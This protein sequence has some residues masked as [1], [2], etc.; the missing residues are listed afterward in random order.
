M[1]S[2]WGR[3]S[4]FSTISRV[5]TLAS[6]LVFV[7][8]GPNLQDYVANGNRY[9]DQKQY[10]KAIVE[11]QNALVLNPQLGEVRAKLADAYRETNDTGRAV[12]EYIRAADLLP[13][14]IP[15]QLVAIRAFLTSARFEDA[16][17]RAEQV[18]RRDPKNAVAE[19]LLG[20][21]LVGLKDMDGAERETEDAIQ[22]D[23]ANAGVQL[24]LAALK[25]TQ[26]NAAAAE[27]AFEKAA[28]LDPSV[29]T[30]LSL[31]NFY[32][33]IDRQSDAENTFK[34]AV[35]AS[36]ADATANRS[37]A[38]FY[39]ATGR[40]RLA[41]PYLQALAKSS[42]DT[43]TRV[44]LA[45]YYV[46]LSEPARAIDILRK[47]GADATAQWRLASLQYAAG[48]KADGHRI[49]DDVL[50]RE[51][52]NERALLVKAN[53]LLKENKLDEA[54]ARAK[55]A[56]AADPRLVS[57]HFALGLIYRAKKQLDESIAA[58]SE[59]LR[60]NPRA[61]AAEAEL[62]ELHL[63]Q[64]SGAKSVEYAQDTL[65]DQPQNA[66]ARLTLVANFITQGDGTRAEAELKPL[67]ARYPKSA[68]VQGYMGAASLLKNND[69]AARQYFEKALELDP[70][71]TEAL[72]GM[73]SLDVR[74]KRLAA[75]R[76]R[77]EAGL[78]K[79]PK[80]PAILGLAAQVYEAAGDAPKVEAT[81]RRAIELDPANFRAYQMLGQF[82]ISTKRLQA[83]REQF[84]ALATRR[85]N[86]VSSHTMV[87]LLLAA[88]HRNS[89]A[90]LRYERILEINPRAAVAAN[91]LAWI[92]ADGDGNL[93]RALELAQTAKSV[94][95]DQPAVNDTL[96]WVYYKKNLAPTAIPLL[97]ASVDRDPRDPI[98]QYHLGLAYAKSG[99]KARARQCLE[100]A[101]RLAPDFSGSAEAKRA[102]ATL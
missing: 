41:E 85:P 23:P 30:Q 95:P 19:A 38:M 29:T 63:L 2:R 42:N 14:N 5:M 81:W 57:A 43:A 17:A 84:E 51:P 54:L 40:A 88:E 93:D 6:V 60:L 3:H 21:A 72:A 97:Q 58:F 74:A 52:K 92:L 67:L 98:Y 16:K 50:K 11:Y 46:T 80:D 49:V 27:A 15:L 89:E 36:P 55:A 96:G 37:I 53:F 20:S 101:L 4:I 24:K 10:A 65:R 75:A 12:G 61:A 86:D 31:A 70:E 91:N 18:L 62:A 44:L 26:G 66:A 33:Y 76:E 64:N 77:V 78:A 102:L 9:F 7:A 39:I 71:S 48:E 59:A 28:E 56:A 87:A 99:D 1:G 68:A 82:Y 69:A 13:D 79:R 35:A 8:C 32:W 100:Q 34:R 83:A 25:V 22:L 47:L 45:D 94:L 73:V 90:Q